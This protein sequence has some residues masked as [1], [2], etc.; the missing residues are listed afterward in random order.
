MVVVFG[1]YG[2]KLSTCLESVLS[3]ATTLMV[4]RISRFGQNGEC[5]YTMAIEG[6]ELQ[7]TRETV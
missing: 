4:N 2:F 7:Q 3:G 6:C 5:E 1:R